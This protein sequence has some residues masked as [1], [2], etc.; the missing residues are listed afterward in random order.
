MFLFYVIL[1]IFDPNKPLIVNEIN[2]TAVS[3]TQAITSKDSAVTDFLNQRINSV[4]TNI[5]NE[6]QIAINPLDSMN[7]VAVW[8]DFRLGYRRVGVGYTLDGGVTWHDTLF[9]GT[10]YEWD[11]DPGITVDDSGNFY[12]VVLSLPSDM[13]TSGIFVFK[14]SDGGVSWQGPYTVID[15]QSYYFEDKEL[16]SADMTDNSPYRGN[17]YVAWT[18]FYDFNNGGINISTSNDGG[19]TWS[20]PVHLGYRVDGVQWPV[21]TVG[22]SGIVYVAWLNFAEGKLEL[23]R[24]SDGGTTFSAPM[25]ITEINNGWFYINPDLLVISYPSI[26]A[27]ASPESPYRGNLYVVY[28]DSTSSNGADIFFRRSTDRGETW[29]SPIRLND[30]S[31]NVITDQFH[32]WIDVDQNGVLT[33]IFY[34]RRNDPNNL[35]MD[36]YIT[37]SFDGGETWTPN[38]RVTSVSSDPSAGGKSGLIGE[39]IGLDV[40]HGR[41]FM[42]WTDTREGTQD[43]YFGMDT[44]ITDIVEEPIARTPAISLKQT[45]VSDYIEFSSDHS[46]PIELYDVFGRVVGQIPVGE[47]KF[48]VKYLPSGMYFLKVGHQ[49]TKFVKVR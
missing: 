35:L 33:V 21:T 28:T 1:A 41:P 39:Y 6:E 20:A 3:G 31:I 30:D 36:L 23:V 27:D 2:N 42:V 18:R 48:Y 32:P 7:M 46:S 34:D 49:F 11:S 26:A 14:S 45:V 22:D 4:T 12:A 44:T 29:S 5:Q 10:P 25:P 9:S 17:L 37:Q 24:S 38:K 13:S 8:R 43:V 47:R 40:W 19:L 15:A 16:I